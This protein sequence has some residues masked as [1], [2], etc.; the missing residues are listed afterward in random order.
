MRM[1]CFKWY[2]V[3]ILVEAAHVAYDGYYFCAAYTTIGYTL[4]T[5]R[6]AFR[7]CRLWD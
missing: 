2:T 1:Q 6:T 3:Y 5:G 4:H 7:E